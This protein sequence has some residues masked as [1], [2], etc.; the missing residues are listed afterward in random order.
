MD[1][2]LLSQIQSS[3]GAL[4]ILDSLLRTC[5]SPSQEGKCSRVCIIKPSPRLQ[6]L[7]WRYQAIRTRFRALHNERDLLALKDAE[8]SPALPSMVVP[9]NDA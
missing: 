4:Y 2:N 5:R 8:A 7:T 9:L 6:S 1:E 3:T